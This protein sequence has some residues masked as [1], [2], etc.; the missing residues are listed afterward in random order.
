ML[1]KNYKFYSSITTL[2]GRK[3][4]CY[5]LVIIRRNS[6]MPCKNGGFSQEKIKKIL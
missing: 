1:L 5:N 2:D 6:G 3:I 4:K